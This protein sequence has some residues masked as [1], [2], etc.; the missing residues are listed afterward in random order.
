MSNTS[1]TKPGKNLL[2]SEIFPL[3]RVAVMADKMYKAAAEI[4][5]A[6]PCALNMDFEEAFETAY[7]TDA[8]FVCYQITGAG[9]ETFPRLKKTILAQLRAI[10]ADVVSTLIVL[11]YDN[12]D[13]EPWL[14]R[15][16]WGEFLSK[17]CA[18]S[19]SWPVAWDWSLLYPTK[20]GAR[21]IYVLKEPVPV[22]QIE[23]KI[24]WLCQQFTDRGIYIAVDQCI[25][26]GHLFRLPNVM[27]DGDPTWDMPY[28]DF[29]PQYEKRLSNKDLGD[30]G[31][32]EAEEYAVL[33]PIAN[34]QPHRD[35][36][37][38]YLCTTSPATGNIIRS[39]FYKEA[40]RRLKNAPCFDCIFNERPIAE[41][42][43]R[44]STIISYTAMAIS[45]LYQLPSCTPEAI[46]ALFFDAVGQLEPAKDTPDWYKFLWDK[47]CMTYTKENAKY[48]LVRQKQQ[49]AAQKAMHILD[50]IAVKMQAWCKAPE[51][52]SDNEDVVRKW[53]MQHLIVSTGRTYLVIT[54]EGT[55]D[56]MQ[57][58]YT[59]IIARINILGLGAA[60][61]TQE[62]IGKGVMRPIPIQTIINDHCTIVNHIMAVPEITGAYIENIDTQD[63]RLIIP[64]YQRNNDLI[65][66]YNSMVDA[67]LKAL[68]GANYEMGV[69]WISWALA[70]D[71]G[72]ICALSI[73]GPAGSGKKMLV[74]G[75]CECLRRP[76]MATQAD[77]VGNVQFNLFSTPFLVVNEGWPRNHSMEPADQFRAFV[78]GDLGQVRRLYC[79]P[80]DIKSPVRILFTA[81]NLDVVKALSSNRD[82]ANDDREA[83]AVRLL[84]MSVTREA[85]DFL[86][87]H[88]GIELTGKIGAR[89]IAG[90]S[91][92]ESDYVV[93][94]HFMYLYQHRKGP[95]GQRFL[96]EGNHAQAIMFDMRTG[97]GSAPIV[98]ETIIKLLEC[99]NRG[100]RYLGVTVE[101][102]ELYVLHTTIMEYF[103]AELASAADFRLT[104]SNLSKVLRGL[105][106]EES[107]RPFELRTRKDLGKK[108]WLMIDSEL[109]YQVATNEGRITPVLAALV[110]EQIARRNGSY[111]G[112][113]VS[114]E[115]APPSENVLSMASA[116]QPKLEL[117]MEVKKGGVA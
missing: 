33:K 25:D 27:R 78:S 47:I 94:K 117:P 18:V 32:A 57:L 46:Y 28:W 65:P 40:K 82:L 53:V 115:E 92:Q 3:P 75:L 23:A 62:M 101:D 81:N 34:K 37:L 80:V 103:R 66:E 64:C 10:G 79:D 43:A 84:H 89:W 20:N 109:L 100:I 108:N 73:S 52:D 63:A 59:Q 104:P 76:K 13:H 56:P 102:G 70:W 111:S 110:E 16:Q 4:P 74:Q 69:K 30:L 54:K 15:D 49:A 51:L 106:K 105:V 96:V 87:L 83:L 113:P 60:I 48:E 107:E 77:L 42:G 41:K 1:G 29:L 95:V 7:Q 61:E 22:D 98:I 97:S 50:L 67:W 14:G 86:N 35:I 91:G 45:I 38:P 58:T 90:D 5:S 44:S 93:A 39:E 26:W 19:D 114:L 72:P 99:R 24:R 55:Y 9:V 71:E 2:L 31:K 88:H 17:L 112:K 116:F 12:P 6:A 85:R 36:I 21:F 68:F 11:D 8:H